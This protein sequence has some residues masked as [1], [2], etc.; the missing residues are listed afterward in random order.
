MTTTSTVSSIRLL[1]DNKIV[2]VPVDWIPRWIALL[3]LVTD[4]GP[5]NGDYNTM[6]PIPWTSSTHDNVQDWVA[7]NIILNE[8]KKPDIVFN[9][10]RCWTTI[11]YM[12]ASNTDYL[13]Y[14]YI[15]DKVPQKN[16]RIV[17]TIR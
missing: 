14:C 7:L 4:L 11:Q 6:E 17:R 2:H 16:R 9:L 1:V 8:E 3:D 12:N 13:N 5:K 10:S 15:D